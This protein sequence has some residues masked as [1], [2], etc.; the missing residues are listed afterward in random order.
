MTDWRRDKSDLWVVGRLLYDLRCHP[1]RRAHE[2]VSLY[3]GVR[4]LARHSK[5]CQLDFALLRQEH[6]G[7]WGRQTQ[8]TGAI[9]RPTRERFSV[10]SIALSRSNSFQGTHTAWY[11]CAQVERMP[12]WNYNLHELHTK[13]LDHRLRNHLICVM[14]HNAPLSLLAKWRQTVNRY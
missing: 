1:E 4:Q 5:V 6:I 7:S 8:S 14:Q 2:G 11:R 3:L 9:K 13:L 10:P 12:Q